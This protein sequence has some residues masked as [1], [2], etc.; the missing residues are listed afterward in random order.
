MSCFV[1]LKNLDLKFRIYTDSGAS[2]K[3]V[4]LNKLTFKKNTVPAFR[5]FYALKKINLE[6]NEGDVIGLIGKNGAGKSTLL[7][8]VSKIYPTDE[9]SMQVSGKIAPL[10]EIGAGFHP[11]FTGRENI[12]LNGSILGIKRKDM[13]KL[14]Q[15]IIDF[16]ELEEFIDLPVKY[17]STGM[18]ARLAF[19]IAT[20]IKPEILI[21]DEIFAGGDGGFVTK[22]VKRM[23]ELIDKSKIVILV[24]HSLDII[25]STCNRVII[26]D[27]GSVI[28]DGPT[29]EVLRKYNTEILKIEQ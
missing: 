22:A 27:K 12:Y 21:L 9:S 15:E 24:S 29:D 16:S 11:E 18:Y 3:Q 17:F 4:I 10:L 25:Q 14:E 7:K 28:A 2:L 8:A 20:S 26:L 1:K 5:E 19:T 23:H 6:F 13:E